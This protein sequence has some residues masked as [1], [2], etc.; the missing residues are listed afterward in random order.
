MRL[1]T[2][3][4][5]VLLARSR[6]AEES[7][8]AEMHIT[9]DVMVRMRDGVHLA[10]DIYRPKRNG[11]SAARALPVILER[12]PYGKTVVSRSELSVQDRQAKSRAEVAR[13]FVSQGYVFVYQDCRGRYDS[14][15]E[16]V[17]Y[18][19]DGLDGFDCLPMDRAAILVQRQD[20]HHGTVLRGAY[21]RCAGLRRVRRASPRC[22]WTAADSPMRFR[23]VFARAAP[24]S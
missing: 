18:L 19:S 14:E 9:S 13:Y 2:A 22:S 21:A 12:T 11:K 8:A 4:G 20:R 1:L 23:M 6:A 5:T 3:T 7:G 10:T 17:K 24:S 16:F 15:G